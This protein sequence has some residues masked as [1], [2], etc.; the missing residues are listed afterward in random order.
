L[1]FLDII[2]G[3]T[4]SKEDSQDRQDKRTTDPVEIDISKAERVH[5]PQLKFERPIDPADTV[6]QDWDKYYSITQKA[7]SHYNR[8]WYAKAKEEW[9]SIY[10][11]YHRDHMYYT[12]LMR[13]YRKL[14]DNAIK[15]KKYQ[16]AFNELSEL[17]ERCS[18]YTNTDIKKYNKVIAQLNKLN[19][20]TLPEKELIVVDEPDFVIES[21]K[22]QLLQEVKK[23]KGY[24]IE[25]TDGT[26]ILDLKARSEFLPEILPHISFDENNIIYRELT[27]VPFIT[28]D[29]YRFR[30]CSNHSSF[31]SSSR[32]LT[33]YHYNWELELLGKFNAFSYSE[34]HTHLRCIEAS[35]DQSCIVFTIIDKAY[36]LDSNM[37]LLA[38]WQVPHKDGYEKRKVEGANGMNDQ[39][40]SYLS[41]LELS[42]KPS[43]EE[44]K[45][46]FRKQVIKWHPDKNPNNPQAEEK[47]KQLI[48]AYEF[49]SG[50]DAQSAFDGIDK[51]EYYWVD[52]SRSYKFDV[53]G[54][55]FEMNF[56][57][58]SGEDW[59][60][61]A[62]ISDDASRI[63]LGCYSGKIYQVN[64]NGIVEK[65]YIVPEDKNGDYGT[66]NPISFVTEYN[67]RKYILTHW[68]LYVLNDDKT[69]S[70]LKNDNGNYRWF[71]KGIILQDKKKIILFDIDGNKQGTITFKSPIKQVCF[72]DDIFLVETTTKSFTFKYNFIE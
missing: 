56:S 64:S 6:K 34:G 1:G 42:D 54:F 19:D 61:G 18:N 57:L 25:Q 68:Y 39:I 37:N 14:I 31:V 27:S 53:G 38:V 36:V 40:K 65:I 16:D 72:C 62:G 44:I 59:I 8:Q 4:K 43:K 17:F 10:D 66:T 69:I 5:L 29:T 70:Y 46:A 63:Y 60:Y 28:N 67:T 49:L 35:A 41:L 11:W 24:K 23:P 50:E 2:K 12:Y 7:H 22:L 9:L 45:I 30:E 13:T 15:K 33:V 51:D 32:E 52:L 58:G 20:T 47:T 26:S 48:Q 3:L 21:D 55:T 71:D